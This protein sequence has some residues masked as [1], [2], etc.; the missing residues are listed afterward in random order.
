MRGR[1]AKA[2]TPDA[3]RTS[4]ESDDERLSYVSVDGPAPRKTKKQK[5]TYYAR[6]D[7]IASLQQQIDALTARLE[8]LIDEQPVTVKDVERA[9]VENASLHQNL[10]V[11][12]LVLA[13]AHSILQGEVARHC[14]NPLATTIRLSADPFERQ[15]TLDGLYHKKVDTATQFILERTKNLRYDQSHR[16]IQGFSTPDGDR[17]LVQCDVAPFKDVASI[18]Q[19]LDD[20]HLVLAHREFQ[21]WDHLGVTTVCDSED[22]DGRPASQSRYLSTTPDGVDIEKNMAMFYRY[23]DKATHLDAPHGVITVDF[24]DEDE[25]YPYQPQYRVRMD[26]SA[27]IL[28]LETPQTSTDDRPKSDS[29][30]VSVLRWAFSRLHRPNFPLSPEKQQALVDLYPQ[31]SEVLRK[32]VREYVDAHRPGH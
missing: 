28:V 12:D 26:V 13:R 16:Q 22:T 18:K 19:V 3:L 11:S 10:H 1:E 4:S 32:V 2:W 31:W 5:S 9:C 24:I 25:L 23:A 17:I 27:I 6:K 15:Q 29:V 7:E 20:I 21:F 14:R 8:Q 30:D